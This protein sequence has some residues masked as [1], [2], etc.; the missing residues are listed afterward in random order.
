[1]T[2]LQGQKI[3]LGVT[4]SIAAYKAAHLL[5][6]LKD[7]GAEVQVVMTQAAQTFITPLTLQ[8]L[9][10]HPVRS[11]LFDPHAEAGLDHIELANWATSIIIAP[12]TANFLAHLAHGFA[13]DLLSTLCLAS[14]APIFLV[15]AMNHRMWQHPATQDSVAILQERS[16]TILGPDEGVQACGDTGLGRM[17]EPEAII[18]ALQPPTAQPLQG[19]KVLI[20]AGPTRE[21]L[22]PVR[23][24]T[25]RSSG[26]MGYALAQALQGLGADVCIISGPV[27]L[28]P[29]PHV[30]CVMVESAIDMYQTVRERVVDHQIFIAT[31][32][33]ADYRAK[34][35]SPEKLKK[36]NASLTLHLIR[37]PDILTAV[38]ARP[39]P[40]FT[41]G[42][43]AETQDL[44]NQAR[45]KLRYKKINMIAA[46]LVGKTQGFESTEN[47]LLVLW[48]NG[49]IA[50]AQQSKI[51]LAQQLALII[52]ERYNDFISNP[53]TEDETTDVTKSIEE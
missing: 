33:V 44:E 8:T 20:T 1:M 4:G 18:A 51:T 14:P 9:S 17:L 10:G 23:Y 41:V 13:D 12:A 50:L 27:H 31:A 16:V 21:A 6:L 30:Q 45:D 46:N 11:A 2:D 15:P 5:R 43:A 53:I 40:P 22:D 42:F 26:R 7:A 28:N 3:L 52:A 47:A 49:K 29:P 37:N 19:I 38:A 32:A 36:D 35:T 24:L 34:T 48:S 25:N 39:N